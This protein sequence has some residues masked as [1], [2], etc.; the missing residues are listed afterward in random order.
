[1]PAT[2]LSAKTQFCNVPLGI[3]VGVCLTIEGIIQNANAVFT[4]VG[5]GPVVWQTLR[6]QQNTLEVHPIAGV[7]LYNHPLMPGPYKL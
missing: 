3:L 1:M 2:V 6:V 5:N 4:C 7:C